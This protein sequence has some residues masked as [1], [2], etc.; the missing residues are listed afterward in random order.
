MN[1]GEEAGDTSSRINRMNMSYM[2]EALYKEPRDDKKE[3]VIAR[4]IAEFGG[5]ITCHE[6]PTASSVSRAVVLTCEFSER[7]DAEKAESALRALGIFT[8]GVG[9]YQE[10]IHCPSE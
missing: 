3:E 2:F 10:I 1:F 5:S 9:D 8:D 7:S 4:K 6:E